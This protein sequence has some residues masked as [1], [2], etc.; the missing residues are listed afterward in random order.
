MRRII[1]QLIL[2]WVAPVPFVV[3][4][5]L[6]AGLAWG[7]QPERKT[8]SAHNLGNQ[9]RIGSTQLDGT[10]DCGE[11]NTT[12]VATSGG[13][14]I[15]QVGPADTVF[16]GRML[17]SGGAQGSVWRSYELTVVSDTEMTRTKIGEDLDDGDTLYVDKLHPVAGSELWQTGLGVDAT[18]KRLYDGLENPLPISISSTEVVIDN[19][20]IGTGNILTY[21]D[22]LDDTVDEASAEI[23]YEVNK[24]SG[25]DTG[26]RISKTDTASAGD[27]YLL[28]GHADSTMVFGFLDKGNLGIAA[29]SRSNALLTLGE[30]LITPPGEMGILYSR[31]FETT[32]VGAGIY[33]LAAANSYINGI[34]GIV[35]GAYLA[36]T[37]GQTVPFLRGIDAG[38]YHAGTGAVNKLQGV[39]SEWQVYGGGSAALI[40]GMRGELSNFASTVGTVHALTFDGWQNTGTVDDSVVAYWDTTTMVGTNTCYSL[41][42]TGCESE[43]RAGSSTTVPLALRAWNVAQT[44]D[45]QQWR[46]SAGGTIASVEAN[47]EIE[48]TGLQITAQY[49]PGVGETCTE[50][51]K[52]VIDGTDLCQCDGSRWYCH[53]GVLR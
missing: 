49:T 20:E 3:V 28:E 15:S 35:G 51:G 39:E 37:D 27:S 26:L 43:L 32:D 38:V 13:L 50:Q 40:Q 30:P 42:G 17:A 22:V 29:E 2:R 34:R 4:L 16:Y 36:S 23:A 21:D 19:L 10:W 5:V 53:T 8:R 11:R 1:E 45:L 41:H 12:C 31:P 24:S 47:G 9:L 7:Q 46:N 18:A 14:L 48:A 44:A 6:A 52:I 33:V 25:D